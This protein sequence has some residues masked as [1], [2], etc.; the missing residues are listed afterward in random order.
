MCGL[1]LFSKSNN[2]VGWNNS[3]GGTFSEKAI[4]V[5]DGINMQVGQK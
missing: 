1:A 3:A 5:Q 2:P 4:N